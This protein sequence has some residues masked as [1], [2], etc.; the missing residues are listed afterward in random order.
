MA[1]SKIYRIQINGIEQSTKAIDALSDALQFLD[2]Q[3]KALESRSINI[4]ST[5][6]ASVSKGSKV[7]EL[8]TQDT[9]LKQIQKTEQQ[10]L[11]TERSEYQNLLAAKDVLKERVRLAEQTA[12]EE[13][14]TANAY[15]NTMEGIKQ[16]LAD[17][18]HVMSGVDLDSSG[19][20]E[21]VR[22]ANELNEKLKQ[23]EASYGQFGRNV[24]NYKS[25]AEG[26]NTLKLTINGVTREFSS[27]R[28]ASRV[29]GNELKTLAIN[30][31]QNTQYYRELDQVFKTLQSDM[32]DVGRSSKAMDTMLDTLESFTSLASVGKGFSA[33]FGFDNSRIEKSIQQLVALQNILNG[34]EKLRLQMRTGEGIG[35][36]L[37]AGN[38]TIDKFVDSLFGVKTELSGVTTA[39]N[40]AGVA[41][42]TAGKGFRFAELAASGL[43]LALK[44]LGVGL[45]ISAI[46]S[47]LEGFSDF[48]K[49]I[50]DTASATDKLDTSIKIL[51]SDFEQ[52]MSVLSSLRLT[53]KITDEEYLNE[54]YKNQSEY[55]NELINLI[56]L[57]NQ[58]TKDNT[59]E[60]TSLE[61]YW[62]KKS[63]Q[64]I[65]QQFDHLNK[66][67]TEFQT[68][69]G[70]MSWFQNLS[71][72]VSK[73]EDNLKALGNVRLDR[74]IGEF[75]KLNQQL[76]SGEITQ[77]QYIES[78]KRLK[79]ELDDNSVLKSILFNL[80]KYIPDETVRNQI[81]GII[82]K[83][84]ELNDAYDMLS[85]SM[86]KY[87]EQVEID[88]MKDG[89]DKTLKQIKLN[90]EEEIRQYGKTQEQ[91]DK[92]RKKY[93]R[94]RLDAQKQANEQALSEQKANAQKW[95][96]AQKDLEDLRIE[97]MK[98]GLNKQ[99]RQLEAERNEKLRKVREE[100]IL[101]G[102]RELEINNLYN[103]KELEAK[104]KFF[105]DMMKLYKEYW[106]EIYDFTKDTEDKIL[107]LQILSDDNAL[108]KLE[109]RLT[110][111]SKGL[112]TIIQSST[113]PDNWYRM[114]G[115]ASTV[116]YPTQ[117]NQVIGEGD[118]T[119]VKQYV[120]MLNDI[121]ILQ[122]SIESH[123]R[124]INELE[125]EQNNINKDAIDLFKTELNQFASLQR[126]IQMQAKDMLDSIMAQGEEVFKDFMRQAEFLQHLGYARDTEQAFAVN[127]TLLE[128]YWGER[129]RITK[130]SAEEQ[131][132]QEK[133]VEEKQYQ[134]SLRKLDDWK[135]ES[136]KKYEELKDK[137]IESIDLTL[138]IEQQNQQREA[139][140]RKYE[141]LT[142]RM[143]QEHARRLETIWQEHAQNIEKIELDKTEKIKAANAQMFR[144]ML[145]QFRDYQ[146]QLGNL[147][148]DAVKMNPFGEN[149][150]QTNRNLRELETLYENFSQSLYNKKSE[151]QRLLDKNEISFDDFQNANRE[152][153]QFAQHLAQK[154]EE[155]RNN[156]S[157]NGQIERFIK[158]YGQYF[159]MALQSIQTIMTAY[160]G[161]QDYEFERQQD[162]LDKQN[163]LIDDK[164]KEQE[165]IINKHSS[166]IND[167]EN[168]LSTARGDRRQELID[169]LNEEKIAEREA[170]AEKKRAE[171][172]KEKLEKE[173][174]KLEKKRRE[175]EYK[176]TLSQ[177][178]IQTA[179]ATVSGLATIPF[180]PRGVAMAALATAMGMAQ[181]AIAKKQKPYAKGGQLE[182]GVAQ[183][184]RHSQ[185]GIKVLGGRAEIEGGEF[186][187]NRT[188]TVKNLPLLEF[189]NS[190]HKRIDLNDLI[191]FYDGGKN[192]KTTV[193][194]MTKTRYADGGVLPPQVSE[195]LNSGDRIIDAFESYANRPYYVSVVEIEDKMDSVKSVRALAGLE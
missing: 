84:H 128:S 136:I 25:A 10:I 6:T 100:G 110:G 109:E 194:S 122:R 73:A 151:L 44:G 139:I 111:M 155:V 64:E 170:L 195:T 87:W 162:W 174:E 36:I 95:A 29:L 193:M 107:R 62:D 114:I 176:R 82:D 76:Q 16:Q 146:T 191:E 69:K 118:L 134:D 144:D 51:S 79:K 126:T 65:E 31:Q 108:R 179:L 119:T 70:F 102:E 147:E 132:K 150:K 103:K 169:R 131:A 177:I 130:E 35:K 184:P 55:L 53:D 116:Q 81:Q 67:L 17:I 98:D 115:N 90:E 61:K 125:A 157:I 37:T 42:T 153:D 91:I 52:R 171:K 5:S 187:T 13:R 43:K 173:Q 113:N 38:D 92:I 83:I 14:L 78:V 18:K 99:L 40:A 182:G 33:L 49:Q 68:N 22:K 145:T 141:E 28:D 160:Q 7:A 59:A 34:I 189:I 57:R 88:S 9:L 149:L 96:A 86:G 142:E 175:E 167:I 80:D 94:Q 188:S 23:I 24:G 112:E 183:G 72:A 158:S 143:M 21:L 135:N 185:G 121:T 15:S 45:V 156:L 166:N 159:T 41:A 104:K 164:L 58:A 66:K 181:Y 47:V 19:F 105:E 124:L 32:K 137:E 93:N 74:F 71:G 12:A 127:I 85:P 8:K 178:L 101:V 30:G 120:S 163:K 97:Q 60:Q 89:L 165:E 77:K 168:E 161:L 1:D 172:E 39:S 129:I 48:V 133:I 2:K 140:E 75:Q 56:N 50:N 190:K 20:D 63:I 138:P 154:M 54:V 117:Y 3:I 186:I 4:G 180:W 152:L 106:Y 26:F 27:A 11:N 46:T 123:Q 148:A 192:I